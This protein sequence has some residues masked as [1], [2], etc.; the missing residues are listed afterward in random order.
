MGPDLKLAA[1]E[2]QARQFSLYEDRAAKWRKQ[3]HA[4][5][6]AE[7]G[8]RVADAALS[9]MPR[10][11]GHPAPDAAKAGSEA[12]SSSAIFA[13]QIGAYLRGE[14]ADQPS[15]VDELDAAL[16]KRSGVASRI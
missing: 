8:V 7:M 6:T 2:A 5:L 3:G 4:H 15:L 16:A 12:S 9:S 1:P 11:A 13:R 10:P 14:V